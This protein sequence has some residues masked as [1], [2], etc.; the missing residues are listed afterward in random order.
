MSTGFRVSLCS[1][2]I[3]A[4]ALPILAQQ[5]QP[6]A[7]RGGQGA[8]AAAG[9]AG[10]RRG[11]GRNISEDPRPIAVFDTVWI[12]EQTWMETRDA[13]KAG[14][15]TAIIAAGSTE[16]NGPYVAAGKH[17]YVLRQTSEAIARKLGNALIAPMIPF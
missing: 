12:E 5:G 8:P 15:T 1:T 9:Q 10:Q 13:I 3:L 11:G 6:S 17:I 7:P 16:Q 14:K 2:V 4:L